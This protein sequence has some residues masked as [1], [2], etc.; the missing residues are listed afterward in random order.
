L[1]PVILQV[2]SSPVDMEQLNLQLQAIAD[3]RRQQE[4][5]YHHQQQQL[6]AQRRQRQQQQLAG[7]GS[8]DC[9]S[10]DST[11]HSGVLTTI[12]TSNTTAASATPSQQLPPP[13][14]S[15]VGVDYTP[16]A[17]DA[18]EGLQPHDRTDTS[19]A[20]AAAEVLVLQSA[21]GCS[22]ERPS[23]AG[24]SVVLSSA[25]SGRL[26][27]QRSLSVSLPPDP[28]LFEEEEEAEEER[29]YQQQ[30]LA[31][32]R[33][34]QQLLAE[35]CAQQQQKEQE[36]QQQQQQQEEQAV[37]RVSDSSCR[38]PDAAGEPACCAG[39][40][41][42][43]GDPSAAVA[44]DGSPACSSA[45]DAAATGE[46]AGA[47]AD[48]GDAGANTA[49]EEAV[50]RSGSFEPPPRLRV[51]RKKLKRASQVCRW[52]ACR[53]VLASTLQT[54]IKLFSALA[55]VPDLPVTGAAHVWNCFSSFAGM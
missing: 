52:V 42:Q 7:T 48:A 13:A 31:E 41:D 11:P 53:W 15:P 51:P 14:S 9:I 5:Q 2:M 35:Q 34:Q 20:A 37:P 55:A 4:Q 23:S 32:Q 29:Q 24:A 38:I 46:G 39:L 50:G 8:Q 47:D 49:V 27:L 21:S 45:G 18:E 40:A 30:Q 44:A 36:Q 25:A 54:L 22:S 10:R 6:S 26:S 33:A 3:S 16:S 43:G 12:S 28:S 1:R 19:A 17:W